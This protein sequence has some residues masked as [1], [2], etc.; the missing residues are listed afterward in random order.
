V[1]EVAMALDEVAAPR[2][3]DAARAGDHWPELARRWSQTGPPL[4]VSPEDQRAYAQAAAERLREGARPRV[5][6][7]GV[8]PE[9]Y[10]LPWPEGTDL[11]AV[12]RSQAMIDHVWLGPREAARC[13]DWTALSLP[14]GSRDLALCDGGFHL[15]EHPGEQARLVRRLG[16]VLAEDGLCALR[17]FVPPARPE[18]PEEVLRDLRR[19]AIPDVNALKLR[20]AMS[21]QRGPE[22]GVRLAEVWD[23]LHAVEPDVAALAS[24]LGWPPEPMSTLEAYRG[25][26]AAYH[27]V[28]I[29]ELC[30]LFCREPGGFRVESIRIPAYPLGER[31]P[32]VALR[33]VRVA[34]AA[35]H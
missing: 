13:E 21:L 16:R 31:C 12:D 4:R 20:L 11:L 26:S 29:D 35:P 30:E 5:L 15:L 19:G 9:L 34:G 8:T 27:F 10:G 18:A 3:P 23:T 24:R 33:R 14:D 2:R 32:L 1:R 6:L 25:A 17:L 28:T 22:R 7:L